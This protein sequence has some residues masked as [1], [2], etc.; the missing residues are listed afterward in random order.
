MYH[1]LEPS[2]P[3]TEHL[4]CA[5]CSTDIS[6]SSLHNNAVL[7]THFLNRDMEAQRGLSLWPVVTQPVQEEAGFEQSL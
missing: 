5:M 1:E 7:V 6:S 3:L 2:L 4:I